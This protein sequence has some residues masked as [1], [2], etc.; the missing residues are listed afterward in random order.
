MFHTFTGCDAVSS[1]SGRGK[2]TAWEIWR[3]LPK[4]TATFHLLMKQSSLSDVEYAMKTLE[5]FV[6]LLYD[7]TS[8]RSHVNEVRL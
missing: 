5:R 2:K 4:I 3:V 6:A 1:F 8:C 7:K